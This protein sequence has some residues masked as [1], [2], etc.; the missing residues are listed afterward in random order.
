[1]KKNVPAAKENDDPQNLGLFKETLSVMFG[2]HQKTIDRLM[3]IVSNSEDKLNVK[4]YITRDKAGPRAVKYL[5]LAIEYARHEGSQKH[6]DGSDEFERSKE[7]DI[8]STARG[9][10]PQKFEPQDETPDMDK[11]IKEC[12]FRD[13]L[14]ELMVSDDPAQAMQ[15]VK[16]AARSPDRYQK[17]AAANTVSQEREV[18]SSEDPNKAEKLRLIQMKKQMQQKE[19]MLRQKEQR[20]EQEMGIRGSTAERPGTGMM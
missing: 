10:R 15:D 12:T 1:V 20:S 16:T 17:Q 7:T 13:Y 19:K 5:R 4:T 6:E 14:M 3:A 11:P 18:K 2:L 9:E 8:E